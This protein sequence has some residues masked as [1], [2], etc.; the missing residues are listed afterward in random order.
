MALQRALN[1]GGDFG[2]TAIPVPVCRPDSGN[3]LYAP[4]I[5]AHQEAGHAVV[6][7]ALGIGIRKLKSRLCHLCACKDPMA[8]WGIC[9]GGTRRTCGRALLRVLPDR[10]C[11]DEAEFGLGGRLPQ[12]L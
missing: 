8:W 4:L 10:H 7:M 9:R 5:I 2:M 11:G 6:A 12:S 3:R 1:F